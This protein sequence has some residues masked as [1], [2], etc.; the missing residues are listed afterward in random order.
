MPANDIS[1]RASEIASRLLGML[2]EVPPYVEEVMPEFAL[3]LAEAEAA[4]DSDEY[5]A[6]R[7]ELDE[8]LESIPMRTK[9]DDM[10][11]EEE[12][13]AR[14]SDIKRLLVPGGHLPS[15]VER[16]IHEMAQSQTNHEPYA[17]KDEVIAFIHEVR[18]HTSAARRR[19][20]RTR[21]HA[22]TLTSHRVRGRSERTA[23]NTRSKGS[24][25]SSSSSSASRGSPD[26]LADPPSPPPRSEPGRPHLADDYAP[27]RATVAA[28][29]AHALS[30]AQR[31]GDHPCP[32]RVSDDRNP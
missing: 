31:A 26:D 22:F 10:E 11:P 29:I 32:E 1:Q 12:I 25:R 18:N 20:C 6:T 3:R 19:D 24:R 5:F 13:E 8:I 17:T 4:G 30:P 9:Y 27:S 15:H 28:S 16:R 14:S 23:C 21:A 7:R 2:R